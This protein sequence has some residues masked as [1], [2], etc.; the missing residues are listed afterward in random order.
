MTS[1]PRLP[2]LVLLLAATAQFHVFAEERPNIL[3]IVAD[4]LGWADVGWHGGRFKTPHMDRL[5]RE[6][7]ELDRHYVQPVCTPTRS[8]LLSGRWNSRFGPQ[9]LTPSNLRAFLPGT[10]TLAGALREAGYQTAISGKWHLGSRKEWGPNAYGFDH[11][12]GALTGAVDPWTHKYRAGEYVDTWHRDGQ[13]LR[14]EGNATELVVS[15]AC[16]QIRSLKGP[17]FLYVP[18]FAVHIPVDAPEDYK[19]LYEGV[20]FHDDPAKDESLHRF[21]AFVSQLDAK[22]GEMISAL[23]QTS[24]RRNT[25]VVFTSDNGGLSSG[26]NPYVGNTPSSP[27]LS[28]NLPL[29]G[30]KNQLHE[31]GIRVCAFANWPGTLQPSKLT[32]SVHAA[33]W[34]PTFT[35]LAGWKPSE[36]PRFDGMNIWPLLTGSSAEAAPRPIY[37]KHPSGSVL[38]HDGWKLIAYKARKDAAPRQELYHVRDDPSETKDLATT[39]PERL[40]QMSA[41]LEEVSR[42]DV[43]EL[44]KDLAGFH[45]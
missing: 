5:V 11:S 32:T 44:P 37:I 18:F 36:P 43:N 34:M 40:Q 29:R 7:V 10:I 20:R 27:A 30:Q 31:G 2:L 26:S 3:L 4:D 42:G 19:R 41:L 45:P 14:E 9:T 24:Q 21:A 1:L 33:D 16:S 13:F 39:E 28:S 22:I 25:L 6:G 23:E 12:Y 17:W 8:S 38:L 15:E 35:A